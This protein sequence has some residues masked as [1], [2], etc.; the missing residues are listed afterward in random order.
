MT[1]DED[2]GFCVYYHRRKDTGEIVYVGEGRRSRALKTKGNHGRSK[3]YTAI[4]DTVGVYV[5]IAHTGLTKTEAELLEEALILQLKSDGV[6]LTNKNK[7]TTTGK[8]YLKEDF[9]DK[10]YIDPS[11]PSGLRWKMNRYSRGTKGSLLAVKDAPVGCK[12]KKTGY[13][14]YINFSCHRIVYALHH[15]ECPAGMTID[16]L[17]GNKDNNA[18]WNLEAVTAGEN[19]RRSIIQREPKR[20]SDVQGSKLT[21]EDVFEIYAMFKSGASNEDV[22]VKFNLH[23]RYVSLLRHG[24]RWQHLYIQYG[25]TFPPSFQKITVSVDQILEAFDLIQTTTLT[26]KAIAEKVGI[27]VSNV[28]RLRHGKIY[29]RI[30]KR[31]R[32]NHE[33]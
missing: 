7:R 15:G 18:I 19:S 28:S 20:G 21:E 1:S 33:T 11:S 25:E 16:H 30:I 26:N 13:W 9:E 27:E 6:P 4:V 29:N 10:F 14:S 8:S 5:D 31:E 22:A 12:S 24:K 32:P 3:A 17:D 23:S 2:R